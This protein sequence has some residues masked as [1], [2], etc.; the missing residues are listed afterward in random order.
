M[1]PKSRAKWADLYFDRLK[2]IQ[3]IIQ[4]HDAKVRIAML[5][6]GINMHHPE[7]IKHKKD[8]SIA[9]AKGFP[10]SLNPFE[11]LNGHGTHGASVL[12]K[13]APNAVLLVAKLFDDNGI[14][15]NNS[16]AVEVI[17]SIL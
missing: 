4:P 17:A 5:D 6:S 14:M 7:M 12:F 15:S 13:T 2:G 10:N 8:G 16:A 3:R 1:N 9:L 11:D